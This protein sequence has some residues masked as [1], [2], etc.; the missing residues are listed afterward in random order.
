VDRHWDL[1]FATEFL[2]DGSPR[3]D[4][5]R[6]PLSG[7]VSGSYSSLYLLFFNFSFTWKA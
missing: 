4:V 2:W 6:G 1:G 7:H 3:V 5:D